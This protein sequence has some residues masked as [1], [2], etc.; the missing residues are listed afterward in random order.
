MS[1]QSSLSHKDNANTLELQVMDVCI[2]TKESD[3]NYGNAETF[4]EA[5]TDGVRQRKTVDVSQKDVTQTKEDEKISLKKEAGNKKK[6]KLFNPINLFGVLVPQNLRTA[7]RNFQ[8]A[9]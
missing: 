2:P 3:E 9:V 6:E 4:V 1:D 8:N 5:G 7:Q